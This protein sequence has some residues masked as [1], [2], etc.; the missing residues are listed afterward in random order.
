MMQQITQTEIITLFMVTVVAFVLVLL[1]AP[2]FIEAVRRAKFG[3]EVRD[4]GPQAHL[5]KQGT[6]TMGGAVI[7]IGFVGAV[8]IGW[9]RERQISVQILQI[10]LLTLGFGLAGFLDDLLKIRRHNSKGLSPARKLFLQLIAALV[11]AV[12]TYYAPAE[13]VTPGKILIPFTGLGENAAGITLPVWLYVPFVV[14]AAL[15]TDNGTN[16]TDGLDGLLSSVTIPVALFFMLAGALVSG[17]FG[18]SITSAAMIGA[19]MGF[20]FFNAYPAKVFMGDTGSLA[21]GGFV[22]AAAVVSGCEL[23]ILIVGFIYLAEVLSVIIQVSYFKATHGKRIFKMAP[24]HHHF[25]M[26]GNSETRI[27][28]AFTIIS[29]LLAALGIIGIWA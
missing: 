3:Q 16:F 21:I 14:L 10:L 17:T 11:F 24:I 9:I 23:Y 13:G 8:I 26:C 27:V 18:I 7:V 12:W 25:E 29:A 6:P 5:S 19:L 20:L 22:A 15:G 1:A 2:S 4:D 28:T